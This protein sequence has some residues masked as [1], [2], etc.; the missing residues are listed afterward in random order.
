MIVGGDTTRCTTVPTL[1]PKVKLYGTHFHPYSKAALDERLGVSDRQLTES[2]RKSSDQAA[3]LEKVENQCE[4]LTDS[5]SQVL[6][7]VGK[8][9]SFELEFKIFMKITCNFNGDYM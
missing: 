4:N 3:A 1:V 9:R 2:R 8:P 6:V 7:S 5:A